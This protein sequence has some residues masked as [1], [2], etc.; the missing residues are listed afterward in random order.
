MDKATR[1]G[2]TAFKRMKENWYDMGELVLEM[3]R[4]PDA[5]PDQVYEV[6]QRYRVVSASVYDARR[7]L[8][9]KVNKA[10]MLTDIVWQQVRKLRR[11]K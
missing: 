10:G 6:A 8:D 11:T 2:I 5:T 1:D 9:E 4:H 3:C 7:V